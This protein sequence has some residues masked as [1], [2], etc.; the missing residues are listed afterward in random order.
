MTLTEKPGVEYPLA[1]VDQQPTPTLPPVETFS[2]GG[3]DPSAYIFIGGFLA[4]MTFTKYVL[5]S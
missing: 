4:G 5:K 2:L 3:L 1:L